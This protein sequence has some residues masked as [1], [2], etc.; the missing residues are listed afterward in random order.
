VAPPSSEVRNTC[1]ADTTSA[2]VPFTL[3]VYT[4]AWRVSGEWS[5]LCRGSWVKSVSMP[6]RSWSSQTISLRISGLYA[7]TL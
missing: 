3:T 1:S 4:V 5:L 7:L 6:A 2:C